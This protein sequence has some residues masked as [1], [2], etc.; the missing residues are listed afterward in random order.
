MII[1]HVRVLYIWF[2]GYA[3]IQLP[4]ALL[5]MYNQFKTYCNK[6]PMSDKTTYKR[7]RST[8]NGITYSRSSLETSWTV[9]R[10]RMQKSGNDFSPDKFVSLPAMKIVS[11]RLDI[12]EQQI[13][14]ILSALSNSNKWI[15]SG[16]T[17]SYVCYLIF[18]S[19]FAVCWIAEHMFS[20]ET[21]YI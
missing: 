19:L 9:K 14:E 6:A 10:N 7:K 16:S 21:H 17:I 2:I 1:F 11:D 3:L 20:F 12:V 18:R 5:C 4:E 8:L 13:Q 15:F